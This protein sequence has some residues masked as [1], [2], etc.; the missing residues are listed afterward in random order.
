[1]ELVFLLSEVTKRN[2]LLEDL[3][4]LTLNFYLFHGRGKYHLIGQYRAYAATPERHKF[5]HC[6]Q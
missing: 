3:A 1:M 2:C 6:L 5:E 4:M